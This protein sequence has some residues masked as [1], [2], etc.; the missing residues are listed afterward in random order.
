MAKK[1]KTKTN[2]ETALVPAGRDYQLTAPV[3]SLVKLADQVDASEF[4]GF[5]EASL[6]PIVKPREMPVGGILFGIITGIMDSP[7]A[8]YKN[9]VLQLTRWTDKLKYCFPITA[10]ISGALGK[11]EQEQDEKIGMR[12][13]IEKTGTKPSK[14]GKK[15]TNMFRVLLKRDPKDARATA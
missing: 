8:E 3:H 4:A 6:P 5:E 12:I 9:R 10:V 13:M 14:K 1:V 2:T 15:D 7:I 11:T